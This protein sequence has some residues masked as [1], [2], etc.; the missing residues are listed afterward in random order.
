MQRVR[1]GV[2]EAPP[3][4]IADRIDDGHADHVLKALEPTDDD[5]AVRPGACERD[6]QV[7]PAR[8]RREPG[9]SVSGDAVPE[10]RRLTDKPP[11]A[12]L[13]GEI[14]RA[15]H[16][17]PFVDAAFVVDG[18]GEPA[19]CGGDVGGVD[20]VGGVGLEIGDRESRR[21]KQITRSSGKRDVHDRVLA[22]MG[23][24]HRHRL[25]GD[26]VGFPA[27][28][29]RDEAGEREDPGG[30]GPVAGK[31][32]RVAHHRA[33]REATEHGP[34]GREAGALPRGVMERGELVVGGV[35]RV[36]IRIADARHRVPVVARPAGNGQR[37]SRGD[38]VQP[39]L[40]IK[41]ISEAEQVM[42][43]GAAA[44]VQDEQPGGVTRGRPLAVGQAHRSDLLPRGGARVH[45]RGQGALERGRR[46]SCW[47]AAAT[48]RRGAPGLRRRRSR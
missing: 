9:R 47:P 45:Q 41:H 21:L 17:T 16:A 37:C 34:C 31:P 20:V 38:D 46:C 2:G 25:A 13:A 23:D 10:C 33:H 6:V 18:R 14:G 30:R 43:I 7:I 22:A 24:E 8:C 44:V 12:V 42:F 3:A 48:P 35:E 4:G 15:H 32:E 39:L 28:D 19:G 36:G 26:Q 27:V 11:V 5:R 40:R 29:R 1:L